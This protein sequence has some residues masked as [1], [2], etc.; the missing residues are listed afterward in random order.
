VKYEKHTVGTTTGSKPSLLISKEER[1]IEE[2]ED[3]IED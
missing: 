1:W 2:S 3:R